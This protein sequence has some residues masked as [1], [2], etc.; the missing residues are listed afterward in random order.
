MSI[1][2]NGGPIEEEIAEAH[3]FNEMVDENKISPEQASNVPLWFSPENID[4]VINSIKAYQESKHDG[5]R[6]RLFRDFAIQLDSVGEGWSFVLDLPGKRIEEE[7]QEQSE[8]EAQTKEGF[9]KFQDSDP[10]EWWK[11]IYDLNRD[12]YDDR[13][14]TEDIARVEVLTDMVMP[15]L[16]GKHILEIGA[17]TQDEW[18]DVHGGYLKL[19]LFF[20]E[21]KDAKYTAIDSTIRKN[22]GGSQKEQIKMDVAEVGHRL[23]DRNYDL[24]LGLAF[25]GAPTYQYSEAKKQDSHKIEKEM[26]ASLDSLLRPGGIMLFVNREEADLNKDD[27]EG[28]G[29]EFCEKKVGTYIYWLARKAEEEK[30]K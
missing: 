14:E 2:Q 27:F 23:K 11:R 29:Y 25:W 15:D 24:I 7:K 9:I 20:T 30:V 19:S 6:Q 22:K 18:D 28:A 13:F 8:F 26:F 21:K 10:E 5:I 4:S 17:F 12:K 1:E 3:K 16:K